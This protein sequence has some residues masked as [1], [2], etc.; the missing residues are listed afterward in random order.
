MPILGGFPRSGVTNMVSENGGNSFDL[1]REK[2]TDIK[3]EYV[4]SL[5]LPL[6]MGR[7]CNHVLQK[8]NDLHLLLF[9]R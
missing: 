4:V 8:R 7:N 9:F 5:K 3:D 1:L 2:R 6:T